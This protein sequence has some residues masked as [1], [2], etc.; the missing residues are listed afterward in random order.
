[1][2]EPITGDKNI[3]SKLDRP[4]LFEDG[5]GMILD[6]ELN[7]QHVFPILRADQGAYSYNPAAPER[8]ETGVVSGN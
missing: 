8:K 1:M 7:N 2:F 3:F 5:V 4:V 6:S